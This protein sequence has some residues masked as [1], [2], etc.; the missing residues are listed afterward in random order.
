[1]I[2]RASGL[3][4][5]GAAAAARRAGVLAGDCIVGL[6]GRRA[7][8]VIDVE[9][10]AADGAFTVDLVRG[11]RQL[12]AHVIL[13]RGEWHGL[14]LEH[15]LGEPPRVCR[16][17]CRFCFVD[18]LPTGLRRSLYV[19][20]DDYRLSFLNGNF[21]T[22]SNL[23]EADLARIE[24]L[25]LSPLY[26]SL[27]DW[28]D[29]RRARLMGEQ[30]RGSRAQLLR[31]ALAG[32]AMHLQVVLCPGWNDGEALDETIAAAAGVD[33][34]V[35]VGVV[36]VSLAVEGDLR[37]VARADAEAALDQIE[38]LQR[39][40]RATKR[41]TFVH[42]ADEFYLL[43][44]RTPPPS[45]A[46]EQ[47]ENGIGISAAFLADAAGA[48]LPAGAGVALLTGT[49]A[50]PVVRAACERLVTAANGGIAQARPYVVENDL[51]GPH[52]TVTGL[53]GG[54]DVLTQLR[55]QPLGDDEW[56]LAPRAFLPEHLGR[57][58]DD[59]DE[60]ALCAACGGRLVLADM[61]SGAFARLRR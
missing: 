27:H 19:K 23:D 26:V 57:T 1:M 20:D 39:R 58:L 9:L 31:L 34:V 54:E 16:N 48:T 5:E 37:R 42:A 11:G 43:C 30:A 44:E 12:E 8:D 49:L 29:D 14:T 18:Q 45:D 22:L 17:R 51:F 28:D 32:I 61:L 25:R 38:K 10:A 60:A 33:A 15:A 41:R 52:V 4:V 47:Y 59:V 53:L 24:R 36:P 2:G 50:Q 21:I 40:F 6:N 35:D 3:I 13:R 56:L 55:Q 46:A 7:D